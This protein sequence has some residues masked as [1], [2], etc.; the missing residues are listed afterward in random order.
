MELK[1]SALSDR[2]IIKSARHI[3]MSV[4]VSVQG[5]APTAQSSVE[6]HPLGP[7][8]IRWVN[9]ES[10][11]RSYVWSP[12][13]QP[14]NQQH[15]FQQ[16]TPY[17]VSSIITTPVATSSLLSVDQDIREASSRMSLYAS[18]PFTHTYIFL[19]GQSLEAKPDYPNAR[20]SLASSVAPP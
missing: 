11:V 2:L 7:T 10:L 6:V 18:Q 5:I 12:S 3:E 13:I 20:L 1:A 9:R 16:D 15:I 17:I 8:L 4:V 19:E 14:S